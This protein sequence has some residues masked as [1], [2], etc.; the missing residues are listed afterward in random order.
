LL[1]ALS[2]LREALC[3]ALQPWAI[4]PTSA[5]TTALLTEHAHLRK[6]TGLR[7]AKETIRNTA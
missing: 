6:R 3:E 5:T 1:H 7:D 2:A 4:A